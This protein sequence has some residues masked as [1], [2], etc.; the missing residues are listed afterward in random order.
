[1]YIRYSADNSIRK[2]K[3]IAFTV[4]FYHFLWQQMSSDHHCFTIYDAIVRHNDI[5]PL[6]LHTTRELD[7][8]QTFM[9]IV[10]FV[11]M[12]SSAEINTAEKQSIRAVSLLVIS[13]K[14][15]MCKFVQHLGQGFELKN[16]TRSKLFVNNKHTGNLAN[17]TLGYF[18]NSCIITLLRIWN[19][20]T[21]FTWIYASFVFYKSCRNQWLSV[22][23]CTTK[24][25]NN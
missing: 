8:S 5:L 7:F 9:V 12:C 22:L 14:W 18:C 10:L 19:I 20:V 21:T 13:G 17:F 15:K 3:I 4:W 1:M 23:T 6:C 16:C 2:N 11:F 25:I 24:P